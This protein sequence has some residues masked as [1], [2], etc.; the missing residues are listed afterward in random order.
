[1][2]LAV[3]QDV[4]VGQ[5]KFEKAFER[6]HKSQKTA[7]DYLAFLQAFEKHCADMNWGAIRT[8]ISFKLMDM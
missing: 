7:E 3:A 2:A 1:M 4:N 5:V 8:C 6:F